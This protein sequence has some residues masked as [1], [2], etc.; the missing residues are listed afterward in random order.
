[1]VLKKCSVSKP[2]YYA[3]LALKK[4]FEKSCVFQSV[5]SV[6]KTGVKV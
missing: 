4:S 3:K 5:S 1:M 6:E 2:L